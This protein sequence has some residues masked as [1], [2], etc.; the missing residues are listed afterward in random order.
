MSKL[1]GLKSNSNAK[2]WPTDLQ[3]LH[4]FIVVHF[5]LQVAIAKS[6]ISPAEA[7]ANCGKQLVAEFRASG[8]N[9]CIIGHVPVITVPPT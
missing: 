8:T 1:C 7:I 5:E 3:V 9:V 6:D 4:D 2:H